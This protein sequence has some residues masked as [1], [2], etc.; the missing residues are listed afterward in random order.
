[1]LSN[2]LCSE[3][4]QMLRKQVKV[5][6]S[7]IE[8]YCVK[9][10]NSTWYP[11]T[12]CCAF[13]PYIRTKIRYVE[14]L[15]DVIA[16]YQTTQPERMKCR[17]LDVGGDILKFLF[18]ALTQSDAQRYTQHIQELENEQQSFLCVSQ[19]QMIILKSAITSFNLTMQKVNKNENVLSENLQRLNQMVVDEI[20]RAQS[21][22]GS[23]L[24]T[25]ENIRQVQ[26]G[27]D[28]CQHTFEILVDTFLHAQDGVI[29]LQ[30]ITVA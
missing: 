26:R 2:V 1:M 24:L 6:Q 15:K 23:V 30:L 28:E 16:D 27:L 8:N 12:D 11:L 20:N 3:I 21:Q 19:E 17:L 9:I 22:L 4:T 10:H 5:H 29:Q 13:T 7:Q 14:Q 18:G 25:N